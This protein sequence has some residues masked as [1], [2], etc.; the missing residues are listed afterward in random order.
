MNKKTRH[1][2]R[3]YLFLSQFNHPLVMKVVIFCEKCG[4]LKDSDSMDYYNSGG[5]LLLKIMKYY[6]SYG[7]KDFVLCLGEHGCV[8]KN[9]FLNFKNSTPVDFV[10]SSGTVINLLGTDID[11]WKIIFDD[12]K[13]ISRQVIDIQKYLKKES[14]FLVN[15]DKSIPEGPL[16]AYLS[17]FKRNNK[18]GKRL[19]NSTS[20]IFNARVFDNF[21]SY[22]E[23]STRT[24]SQL[25]ERSQM[26]GMAFANVIHP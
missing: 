4:H 3:W 9:Y 23:I 2:F 11:D 14:Y 7:H 8:I 18:D 12:N 22:E 25:E 5:P 16:N 19:G 1:S 26:S 17:E 21:H 15:D 20:F 13:R 6:A 10:L 24:F